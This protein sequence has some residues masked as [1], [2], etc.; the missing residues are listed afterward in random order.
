MNFA[1]HLHLGVNTIRSFELSNFIN[2]MTFSQLR[3][4]VIDDCL[5]SNISEIKVYIINK[6]HTESSFLRF[7]F[8][9]SLFMN[10]WTLSSNQIKNSCAS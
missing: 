2:F 4:L 10:S 3:H 1:L 7:L 6:Y 8:T 5:P 9:L